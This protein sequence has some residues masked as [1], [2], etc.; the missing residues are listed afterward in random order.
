MVPKSCVRLG[1]IDDDV[2]F[3][4]AIWFSDLERLSLIDNNCST[5]ENEI[6]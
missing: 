4:D 3:G 2:F 6:Q 5:R 1:L